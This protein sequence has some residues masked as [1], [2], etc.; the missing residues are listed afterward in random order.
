MEIGSRVVVRAIRQIALSKRPTR[1]ARVAA[2]GRLDLDDLG[3]EIEQR[4]ADPGTG[5]NAGQLDHLVTRERR[6]IPGRRTVRPRAP[7]K[8][9]WRPVM[10][11]PRISAWTSCVPS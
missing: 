9:A 8:K 6:Q 11:R 4:P 5:Q 1:A 2:A 10:A 7:Q 3:A